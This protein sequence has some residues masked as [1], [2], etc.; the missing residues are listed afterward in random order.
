[1]SDTLKLSCKSYLRPFFVIL[2]YFL[3]S[4]NIHSQKMEKYF[5]KADNYYQQ[6]KY[7]KAIKYYQ[8]VITETEYNERAY[9]QSA[10]CYEKIEELAVADELFAQVFFKSEKVEPAI[11]LEYGD[12]LMKLGKN[13][14]A[15]SYYMSYN[16]LME[17]NDL[18]VLRNLK[19]IEDIEKYYLD[20]A[21]INA[22]LLP[23]SSD[24]E[25]YNPRVYG[26]Y[27]YFE[28]NRDYAG[29]DPKLRSIYAQSIADNF[30]DK[31][32]K[33][34]ISGD[35]RQVLKGF[36]IAKSTG[37][38]L[39]SVVEEIDNAKKAVLK[40]SFIDDSGTKLS[41]EEKVSVESFQDNIIS[42]TLSATGQILVFA[43]DAEGVAGGFDLY[44]SYR[45]AYGYGKPIR[46]GGYINTSGNENYPY[47]LNDTILFFSSDGHGGL[48]GY[49]V[50]YINLNTPA[51]LPRNLGS[52]VNSQYDEYGLALSADNTIGYFVSDRAAKKSRADIYQFELV[53]VRAIGEV[54]DQ[55]TGNNLK[56]VAVSYAKPGEEKF[57]F[58]LADNGKF[59]LIGQP[60]EE[61][62]LTI[63]SEGYEMEEFYVSTLSAT[64]VGLYEVNIGKFPILKIEEDS[65]PKPI[66]EAAPIIEEEIFVEALVEEE[67]PPLSGTVFRVQI[68]ASRVPLNE[69]ALKRIYIGQREIFMFEEEGWYKYAIGNFASYYE[70]NAVRKECGVKGAF[71]A[72]Y[73]DNSKIELMTAIKEL[74]SKPAEIMA[75]TA[76]ISEN[77]EIVNSEII[78]YPFDH[79]KPAPS[80]M[81]KIN[82]IID[83]LNNHR[84]YMIEIDGH[85][86][87]QG[88]KD[89][90]YGLSAARAK[91]IKEYLVNKGIAQDRIMVLGYGEKKVR[92]HC[93]GDCTPA[94]HRENRRAEIIIYKN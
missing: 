78:Y 31:S 49:D 39:K 74:H 28:S 57:E 66:E 77:R 30:S 34:S 8:K 81:K 14:E 36:A 73:S 70:A 82:E 17:N 42:P 26:N 40:R 38:V 50:Y 32:K 58:A 44:I 12:L 87:V 75:N 23:L 33:I 53:Q 62:N 5:I 56:N 85:T 15:R 41:K 91:Y 93:M 6:E 11:F 19:S 10:R 54:T 22:E 13:D 24:E 67:P 48:G 84:D 89:Y 7:E 1:M 4:P 71:I 25:D 37:E 27:L 72:A 63:W 59:N 51:S 94:N 16:N 65:I 45:D 3:I 43:S 29:S 80:E 83:L 18:R 52:P 64:P 46:L 2:L 92:K 60:D 47:L 9:L 20:T 88:S 76:I 69:S 86:D 35:S 21:F 55:K 79:Y 90:N 61:Y 68:A